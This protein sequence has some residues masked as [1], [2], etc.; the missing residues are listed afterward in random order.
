VNS[1]AVG[2]H[3]LASGGFRQELVLHAGPEQFV[4]CAARFAR[5]AIKNGESV[6]VAVLDPL[7]SLV[8][9]ELGPDAEH[10]EFPDT[11]A[12]VRNPARIIPAWREWVAQHHDA[13]RGICGISQPVI[14]RSPDAIVEYQIHELLLQAGLRPW[15]AVADALPLRHEFPSRI[16]DRTGRAGSWGGAVRRSRPGPRARR[17]PGALGRRLHRVHAAFGSAL[18]E[19]DRARLLNVREFGLAELSGV[20]AAA[21]LCAGL[22]GG[23]TADL[24]LVIGELA[25]NSIVH[26]GVRTRASPGERACG[27]RTRCATS[28]RSVPPPNPA[29]SSASGCRSSAPRRPSSRSRSRAWRFRHPGRV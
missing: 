19:L 10:V 24:A 29:P 27:S 16:T 3:P 11:Q 15:P 12:L 7:R 21:Q 9:A 26:A 5:E 20:R 28:C 8:Q 13:G 22:L 17:G 23:R 6:I 2:A 4:R 18:P 1:T 14:T 25:A